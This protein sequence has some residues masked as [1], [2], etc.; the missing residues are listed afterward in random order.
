MVA[1]GLITAGLGVGR[2]TEG[3]LLAEAFEGIGELGVGLVTVAS[4]L[5]DGQ[6]LPSLILLFDCTA[7]IEDTQGGTVAKFSVDAGKARREPGLNVRHHADARTATNVI[8]AGQ[9]VAKRHFRPG[10][11]SRDRDDKATIK[12]LRNF[13][14]CRF[15]SSKLPFV[16]GQRVGGEAIGL[17][18]E[19]RFAGAGDPGQEHQLVARRV[20]RILDDAPQPLGGEDGGGVVQRRVEQVA[21]VARRAIVRKLLLE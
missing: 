18:D 8:E 17:I 11:H 10:L 5:E 4:R 1:A 12:C 2:F 13:R 9:R 14:Q 7:A 3:A 16:N 21:V 19:G 15:G 20:A 6:V